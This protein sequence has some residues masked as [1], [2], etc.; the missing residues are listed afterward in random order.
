MPEPVTLMLL[1]SGLVAVGL[2]RH[3]TRIEEP[4]FRSSQVN[5][6]R[7]NVRSLWQFYF[8]LHSANYD[9]GFSPARSLWAGCCESPPILENRGYLTG[10]PPAPGSGPPSRGHPD[11]GDIA[12]MCRILPIFPLTSPRLV[13][14]DMT[15]RY[16]LSEAMVETAC[17]SASIMASSPGQIT[18]T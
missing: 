13:M 5:C 8:A 12:Q 3:R 14:T 16:S 11:R 6:R 18:A 10:V 15:R 9:S 4:S 2:M 17:I 7:T 1:R